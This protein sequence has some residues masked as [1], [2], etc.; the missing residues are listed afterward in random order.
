[1]NFQIQVGTE[2]RLASEK[3]T[4]V[5]ISGTFYLAK[6]EAKINRFWKCLKY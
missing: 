6:Y 4:I 3:L 1:M 5:V 2:V